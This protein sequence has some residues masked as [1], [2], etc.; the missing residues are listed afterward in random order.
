V[1]K[2]NEMSASSRSI[3]QSTGVGSIVRPLV[4][5]A[6]ALAAAGSIT[7]GAIAFTAAKPVPATL[8]VVAHP[9]MIERDTRDDLAQPAAQSPFDRGFE[10]EAP[11]ARHGARAE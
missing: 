6:A 2:E 4:L 9:A 5:A 11:A 8:S 3:P 1:D 7:W 10:L